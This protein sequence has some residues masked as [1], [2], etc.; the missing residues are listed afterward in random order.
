M[1]FLRC[2]SPMDQTTNK[3]C[4]LPTDVGE[5]GNAIYTYIDFDAWDKVESYPLSMSSSSIHLDIPLARGG[6][7]S[8]IEIEEFFLGYN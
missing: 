3:L 2:L 4:R 5:F 7:L 1:L 6:F 8:K